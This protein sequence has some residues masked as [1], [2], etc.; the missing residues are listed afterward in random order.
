MRQTA[1]EE[2][3]MIGPAKAFDMGEGG[4]EGWIF[5]VPVIVGG[6]CEGK[7]KEF[8]VSGLRTNFEKDFFL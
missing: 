7:G 4:K 8:P 5:S 6:L 1:V 2:K 3:K